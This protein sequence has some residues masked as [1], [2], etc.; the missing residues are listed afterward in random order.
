MP[1]F[2][3]LSPA[4]GL[5]VTVARL[6]QL[7]IIASLAHDIWN[8]YYP[9]IISKAQID[10]MLRLRYSPD[11]LVERYATRGTTMLIAWLGPLAVGFA[12]LSV[13]E[14]ALDE[15]NLD[16]FYLHP[17]HHRR[18]FGTVF[19]EQVIALLDGA[20]RHILVL[21]VNR[22]NITAINFYF[23]QGFTIRSAVDVDLGSGY[24]GDDFIM[25]RPLP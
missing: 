17:D 19:I 3:F 25:E 2:V 8:R 5:N 4:A 23:R 7:R 13:P 22:K 6:D 1:T 16:A 20:P 9:S 15:T 21:N 14:D 18:G 12:V 11:A 24:T 10:Y